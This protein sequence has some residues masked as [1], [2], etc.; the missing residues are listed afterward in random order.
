MEIGVSFGDVVNF[1][2]GAIGSNVDVKWEFEGSRV[3]DCNSTGCDGA[4]CS[5]RNISNFDPMNNNT[6]FKSVLWIDTSLPIGRA[7]QQDSFYFTCIAS[8]LVLDVQGSQ[9]HGM[10]TATLIVESE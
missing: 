6:S 1:T 3:C 10:F 2:C 9:L 7:S 4:V 8:Q 5:R